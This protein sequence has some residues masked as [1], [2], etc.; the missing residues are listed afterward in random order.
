M[1][2]LAKI[3]KMN[4]NIF[5]ENLT[6]NDAVNARSILNLLESSTIEEN[7]LELSVNDTLDYLQEHYQFDDHN[8]YNEFLHIVSRA[9]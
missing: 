5:V 2:N 3:G 6:G 8:V 9:V 1:R 7:E 4:V